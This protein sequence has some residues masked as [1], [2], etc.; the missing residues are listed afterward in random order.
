MK[1]KVLLEHMIINFLEKKKYST[2]RLNGCVD[3]LAKK[4]ETY[5]LKILFNLDGLLEWHAR[6]LQAMSHFLNSYPFV[7][8]MVT[9][10]G[11]LEDDVIYI[12]FGLPAV[13]PKTFEKIVERK[14]KKKMAI[15]GKKVVEIDTKLLRERRIKLN[16]SLR[17]LAKKIGISKKALYEIEKERVRPLAETA[18]K[19]EEI[20]GIKL[21]KS[22]VPKV[23]EKTYA[24]PLTNFQKF[25][26]SELKEK[27]IEN[28]PVYTSKFN[29]V[30]RM[31]NS[32]ISITKKKIKKYQVK[33]L[34]RIA[35]FLDLKAFIVCEKTESYELPVITRNELRK[36]SLEDILELLS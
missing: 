14:E 6:S 7:I 5:L 8:S 26:S 4:N 13:T 12:R 15:K 10:R 32:L 30:A 19:L 20:L 23:P 17:E 34:E 27:G 9:N 24:E 1:E 22:Y 33:T 29:L 25:V 11:R 16:F 21:V 31:E 18:K 2:L 35:S 36:Y 3:L 28:S